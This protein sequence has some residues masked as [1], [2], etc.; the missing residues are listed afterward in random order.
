M[1]EAQE[2]RA[3]QEHVDAA[4]QG[5][6][7]FERAVGNLNTQLKELADA[8]VD[9][10]TKQ[11]T[12]EANKKDADAA[13]AEF[14]RQRQIA[15]DKAA[16]LEQSLTEVAAAHDKVVAERGDVDAA[17]RQV[18]QMASRIGAVLATVPADRKPVQP[19]ME[20]E[21]PVQQRRGLA[22]LFGR[23]AA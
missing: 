14:E 6:N 16:E 11:A 7:E 20:T 21:A 8:Q 23:K 2:R 19:P 22:G 15:A 12:V 1:A 18:E 4:E 10:A 3:G 9:L 17:R 13:V 5:L